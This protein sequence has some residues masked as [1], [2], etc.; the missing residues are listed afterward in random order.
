M[1][2]TITGPGVPFKFPIIIP[3]WMIPEKYIGSTITQMES[4]PNI[5]KCLREIKRTHGSFVLVEVE[6]TDGYSIK[7]TL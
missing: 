5:K 4:I 3:L 6:T 1:R 2:I 7:I